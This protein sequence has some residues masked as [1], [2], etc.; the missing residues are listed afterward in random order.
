[1]RRGVQA[2]G[3]APLPPLCVALGAACKI[4]AACWWPCRVGASRL[5]GAI[6]GAPQSRA[7]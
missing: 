5:R 7:A 2:G 3:C 6:V 1:M 4:D